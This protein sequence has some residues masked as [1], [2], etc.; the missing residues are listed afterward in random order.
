MEFT[1]FTFEDSIYTTKGFKVQSIS[2]SHF[3]LSHIKPSIDP[4]LLPFLNGK[5][6]VF[7]FR[8]I[9]SDT[10]NIY[11]IKILVL[12]Y[13]SHS[14]FFLKDNI[15]INRSSYYI[16]PYIDY[17]LYWLPPPYPEENLW[18]TPSYI[19]S[20]IA[21]VHSPLYKAYIYWKYKLSF[22]DIHNRLDNYHFRKILLD[23]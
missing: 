10:S 19:L 17:L 4:Q 12:T 1:S 2:K 23:P 9:T 7:T 3:L 20:S 13:S 8:K 21:D 16:L 14:Y 6:G 11:R 5:Q 22:F 18:K 15:N